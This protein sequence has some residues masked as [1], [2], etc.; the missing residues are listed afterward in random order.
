MQSQL[1]GELQEY[2]RQI[3][4]IQSEFQSLTEELTEEQLR[5][6]PAPG[7]WSIC[8]CLVH[9]N[10]FG[11]QVEENLAAMIEKAKGR[12]LFGEGPFR[13]GLLGQLLV[14][15]IEP[16]YR[17]RVK[18]VKRLVPSYAGPV[19]PVL[20]EFLALQ[21][22]LRQKLD[23]ARG[24]DLAA[25]RRPIPPT[26]LPLTLGQWFALCLAHERRHLW[27]AA[28]IRQRPTFPGHRN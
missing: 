15:L 17:V 24:L 10:L 9:L 5:W 11:A 21:E 13:H 14:R 8:D 22:R 6:Q 26:Y 27:Q 2:Q 12:G 19:E 3:T 28:Q 1:A 16:P 18:A 23:E 20:R 4:A 25:V 7:V